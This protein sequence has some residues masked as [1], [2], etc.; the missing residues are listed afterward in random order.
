MLEPSVNH[1]I[2]NQSLFYLSSN[3]DEIFSV[4]IRFITN[5]IYLNMPTNNKK[6]DGMLTH[7]ENVIYK[8]VTA[9]WI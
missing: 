6:I 1:F 8:R 2:D 5:N 7:A 3:L 9:L 4:I